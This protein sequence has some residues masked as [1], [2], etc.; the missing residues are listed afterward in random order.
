[1]QFSTADNYTAW[2]MVEAG[3]GSSMNNALMAARRPGN[4]VQL[5]LE[6]AQTI[7]LGMAVPCLKEVSPAAGAFIRQV[8]QTMGAFDG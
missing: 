2:C 8:R 3:L 6:P 4:V 1:M 5:P 7:T